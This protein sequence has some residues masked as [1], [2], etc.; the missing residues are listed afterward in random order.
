[1]R[2]TIWMAAL[3]MAISLAD[4]PRA[5]EA[6][7]YPAWGDTGWMYGSKRECCNAAIAIAQQYS[8]EACLNVG[9]TP[10]PMRGGAARGSCESQWT[11]GP[12]GG[13]LYRCV[14]ESAVWCR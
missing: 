10:R 5:V 6:S 8:M 13:M 12:D 2:R 4:L 14:S 7:E 3:L 11:Q 1:M 9:G